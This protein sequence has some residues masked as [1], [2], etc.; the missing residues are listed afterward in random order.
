MLVL[1]RRVGQVIVI[2]DHIAVVVLA[3]HGNKVR[4]GVKAPPGVRVDRPGVHE[5]RGEFAAKPS[6]ISV[7]AV[8]AK[9]MKS[10]GVL[11]A[12]PL[13]VPKPVSPRTAEVPGGT[14]CWE[15]CS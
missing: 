10:R 9:R 4:V 3:V 1:T 2:D 11:R 5:R 15:T 8:L 14:C 13:P 7:S 12:L 6:P